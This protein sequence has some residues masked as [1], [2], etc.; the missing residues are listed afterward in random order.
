MGPSLQVGPGCPACG[1]R[2]RLVA[3]IAEPRV[4]ARILAHLGLPGEPPP[5]APPRQ[6]SWLPAAAD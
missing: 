5:A 2:L 6:P 4:I 1:G 3:T